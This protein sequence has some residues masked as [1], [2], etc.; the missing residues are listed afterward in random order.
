MGHSLWR[1][2]PPSEQ[3]NLDDAHRRKVEY[4]NEPTTTRA[5]KAEHGVRTVVATSATLSWKGVWSPKSA[6]ELRRLG[7]VRAGDM[8]VVAT[9]FLIGNPATFRTINATTSME[10]RA[11]IG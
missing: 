6:E 2:P 1:E 10:S 7:C 9:R 11:G 4:Y 8:K 3:T 5:I